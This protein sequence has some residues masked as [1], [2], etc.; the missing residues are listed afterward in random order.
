MRKVKNK[1]S[2]KGRRWADT[3]NSPC[4]DTRQWGDGE[5]AALFLCSQRVW[6]WSR[7]YPGRERRCPEPGIDVAP[8][9]DAEA[10]IELEG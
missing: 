1:P 2:K 4:D 7:W 3:S 9:K 8:V 10:E 6:N 5:R